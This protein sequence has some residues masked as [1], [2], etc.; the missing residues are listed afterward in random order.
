[1]EKVSIIGSGNMANWLVNRFL[2]ASIPIHEIYS[3]NI[4]SGAFLA[5]KANA[6][7]ISEL[8]N[9]DLNVDF[10]LLAVPDD[11]LLL[12]ANQLPLGDFILVGHSGTMEIPFHHHH[13]KQACIWPVFSITKEIDTS[14][15]TIP[16]SINVLHNMEKEKVEKF[17]KYL[18]NTTYWLDNNQKKYA[19][20]A[21]TIGNNFTNHL[22]HITYK[23]ASE[24]N[25]PFE[26]LLP[27]FQNTMNRLS[28][29]DPAVNQT[30]PA[31]RDDI[32]TIQTHLKLLNKEE[33]ELYALFTKMIKQ[34]GIQ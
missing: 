12:V 23:I 28:D 1:V 13:K 17:S 30:G 22:L 18:S 11:A 9:L 15:E 24:N 32:S 5:Q 29:T 7:W 16:L 4:E 25:I 31:I 8:K 34:Q 21:A 26:L 33:K 3:R 20:L 19:H 6:K 10:I 14:I 2:K 27:L